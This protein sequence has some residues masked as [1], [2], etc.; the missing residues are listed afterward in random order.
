M[1]SSTFWAGASDKIMRLVESK[2]IELVLSEE[3]VNEFI[4]V[5]EYEEVK[6]KAKGLSVRR[7]VEK[8]L[9]NAEIIVPQEK[10][11]I[12]KQDPDDDKV[13]EC[14]VEG[15]SNFIITQDKHLLKMKSYK[16]IRIITPQEFL[17]EF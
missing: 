13:I 2:E 10:L 6:R 14:A 4:N 7:T 12:V 15:K 16:Q 9:S 17:R 5:L 11:S 8:I 1:L 3:I